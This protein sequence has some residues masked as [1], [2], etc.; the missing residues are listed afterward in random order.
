MQYA[1]ERRLGGAIRMGDGEGRD[2]AEHKNLISTSWAWLAQKS[3]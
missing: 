1:G 3:R 2:A